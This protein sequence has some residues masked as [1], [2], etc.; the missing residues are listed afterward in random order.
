M[1]ERKGREWVEGPAAAA[2]A[3]SLRPAGTKPENLNQR[4]RNLAPQTLKPWPCRYPQIYEAPQKLLVRPEAVKVARPDFLAAL[5]AITPAAHRRVRGAALGGR[6]V[7]LAWGDEED[8]DVG[9]AR[10]LHMSLGRTARHHAGGACNGAALL[11]GDGCLGVRVRGCRCRVAAD[12]PAEC[13]AP[14]SG[15]GRPR[16]R[17]FCFHPPP[18]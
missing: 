2:P 9:V 14:R 1:T 17:E 10:L 11:G 16:R 18:L 7:L 12:V 3:P 15:G 6:R 8:A 13:A 4:L 5:S